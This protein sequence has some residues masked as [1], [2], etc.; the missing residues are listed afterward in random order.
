MLEPGTGVR[1]TL[2]TQ[3]QDALVDRFVIGCD[4]AAFA[5]SH[6]LVRIEREDRRRAVRADHL[7]L[8]LSAK[9]LGAVLNDRETVS[10]GD[11]ANL[12][13]LAGQS[14]DVDRDDRLGAW[15]NCCLDCR[16]VEV[17]R[18]WVDFR[19]RDIRPGLQDA[20]G[21]R[22]EREWRGDDLIAGADASLDEAKMK[23][24]C[25]TRDRSRVLDADP[26]G[27][28]ALEARP[29]RAE[30]EHA[31]AQ[32]LEHEL[33]LAWTDIRLRERNWCADGAHLRRETRDRS[34]TARVDRGPCRRT[35]SGSAS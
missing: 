20:V 31:R 4:N 2:V 13:D 5:R 11:R 9:C 18:D 24:R 16:W 6:L 35:S 22:D 7:P 15:R 12:L 28:G 30:R 32:H 19:E 21:R 23:T 25:A 27:E 17:K 26:V 33:F 8:T 29:H 14:K 10:I 3:A 1:T 34:S